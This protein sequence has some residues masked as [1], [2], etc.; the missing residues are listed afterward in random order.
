MKLK[1]YSKKFSKITRSTVA[2]KIYEIMKNNRDKIKICR[3]IQKFIHD[4]IVY[5]LIK[6]TK[7][8]QFK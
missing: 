4:K 6:N 1:T 2:N 3:K 8:R 7:T 5:F